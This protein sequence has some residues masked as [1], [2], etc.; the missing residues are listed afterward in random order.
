MEVS[1][2]RP[3]GQAESVWMDTALKAKTMD[4]LYFYNIIPIML[5][6]T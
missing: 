4:S 1:G 2:D 5:W 6:R 3:K